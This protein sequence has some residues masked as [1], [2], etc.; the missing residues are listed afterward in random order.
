V[1]GSEPRNSGAPAI[2]RI[3]AVVAVVAGIVLAAVVLLGGDSGHKYRLIF[4]TGGQLVQGNLVQVGGQPVGT[5]D[6]IKLTDDARAEV[7]I[8]VD[9]P[10]H[11]GTTATVRATSLSGI[12]N[13]YVSLAPGPNSAPEL[14]GD[15]VIA[16]DKTTS[17]VDIDQLFDTFNHRTR[18]ALAKFIQ[19]QATVYGG[20]AEQANQT[21]K[22]LAPGLQSTERLLAELTR[23][24][25]A[26]SQF[27]VS[28]SSVL[29]AVAQ[30][31]ADLTSLISNA[32]QA[33]GAIANQNQ[34]FDASLVELPPTLRQANTT[35]VNLRAALDDLQPLIDTTGVATRDLAPFLRELRPIVE[36]SVPVFA[37]LSK[38]VLRDGPANDLVD[39][40]RALPGAE[41][42]AGRSV[43]A[44]I[45]ALDDS[46]TNVAQLR[47]YSPD[48]VAFLGRFSQ[49]AANYDGDGHY[50]RV[51]PAGVNFFSWNPTTSVLDP[52]P[53][54]QQFAD[55]DNGFFNRCPGG[56]TQ[57]ISGSNPFL[58]DGAL[59]GVCDPAAVPPGP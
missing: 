38:T 19:G 59:D 14:P 30:R 33:L 3:L 37:D 10:L 43:P 45:K 57:P 11:E 24:Q 54:A 53:A 44:T 47:A 7:T 26:F 18:T 56:A 15:A 40:L 48:L 27:L 46:Q 16:E 12:A 35:F 42:A 34:A 49:V 29:D 39:T 50:L 8:T 52:I 17:P 13:R 22:Y 36:D 21:Y 1:Q 51:S 31:R 25:Q 4:E 6:D 32:N 55:F 58:D 20:S 23:D 41:N 2:F 9:D 5:V 28:G